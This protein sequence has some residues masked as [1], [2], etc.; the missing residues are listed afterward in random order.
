MKETKK[1][2]GD[3]IQYCDNPYEA[4]ENTDAMALMTEWPEFQLPNF[5]KMAG[6]MKDRVIF[7]G[8]NIY[9]P[10]LLV[11]M[12]FKYYGI[13]RRPQEEIK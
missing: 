6:I 3:S 7:D 5:K 10:A 4:L 13:G 11:K 12:G 8:R 2:L 9:D 1:L